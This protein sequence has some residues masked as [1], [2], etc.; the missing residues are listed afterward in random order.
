[1]AEEKKR[2]LLIGST[3]K[4]VHLRN[5]FHLIAGYFDEVL[6][7]SGNKVDFCRTIVLDFGL[8]KPANHLEIDP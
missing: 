6:I 3:Q 8:K 7:V 4:D 1:M 5:Y 2:L